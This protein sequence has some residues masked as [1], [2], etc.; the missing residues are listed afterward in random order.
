EGLPAVPVPEAD[1]VPADPLADVRFGGPEWFNEQY[2]L[3]TKLAQLQASG[4]TDFTTADQVREAIEGAGLTAYEHFNNFSL[5][6]G[7]SPSPYFNTYEYLRGK[8]AQ[9]NAVPGG[10]TGWDVEKV[11]TAFKAAG[12]TSAWDH[13]NAFG[14]DEDINPSNGFDMSAYLND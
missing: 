3:E 10:P 1:Q 12:F 9:L 4:S 8:V 5:Q 7:T 11:M 13:F 6:E 2:Y 14:M